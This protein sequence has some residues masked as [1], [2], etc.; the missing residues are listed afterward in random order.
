VL[1]PTLVSWIR[2]RLAKLLESSGLT[3]GLGAF[4]ARIRHAATLTWRYRALRY[5][6]FA[7]RH[8]TGRPEAQWWCPDSDLAARSP[9][10]GYATGRVPAYAVRFE[11]A[12]GERRTGQ[13]TV[14]TVGTRTA[15][16]HTFEVVRGGLRLPPD[17]EAGCVKA[18][19]DALSVLGM[20]VTP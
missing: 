4:E 11:E 8:W 17:A 2:G 10:D 20:S 12:T 15:Q 1:G 7:D 3:M 13:V 14:A 9:F 16:A 18:T 19:Y 6:L 5:E